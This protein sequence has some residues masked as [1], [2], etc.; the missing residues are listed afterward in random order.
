[1][2]FGWLDDFLTVGGTIVS[3]FNPVIGA[4]MMAGGK[5]LNA[6]EKSEQEQ[7]KAYADR[8]RQVAAALDATDEYGAR[9]LEQLK[10]AIRLDLLMWK[11]KAPN[12]RDV[13][14]YASIIVK[15]V[16]GDFEASGQEEL[17]T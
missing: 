17:P 3:V 9:K 15:G 10:S 13:E 14:A 2:A 1:M 8:W 5:V 7:L 6:R 4:G 16:K 12:E 11:G